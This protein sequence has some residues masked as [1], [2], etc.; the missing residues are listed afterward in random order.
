MA[1]TSALATQLSTALTRAE[2]AETALADARAQIEALNEKLALARKLFYEQ[3]ATIAKFDTRNS[4][5]AARTER[6]A[7]F[8]A[9]AAK[10]KADALRFFAAHPDAK[11]ATLGEIA[12]WGE[13]N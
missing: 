12:A 8:A 11:S 6:A 10:G 3:R 9:A 13:A 4:Y 5:A 7:V 1:R 2:Q